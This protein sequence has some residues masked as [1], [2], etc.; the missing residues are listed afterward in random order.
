MLLWMWERAPRW[1]VH[2]RYQTAEE[3]ADERTV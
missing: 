3:G 2:R 1:D